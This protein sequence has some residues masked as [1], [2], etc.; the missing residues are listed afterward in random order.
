MKIST[1]AISLLVL[2]NLSGCAKD[3]TAIIEKLIVGTWDSH[4]ID[5]GKELYTGRLKFNKDGTGEIANEIN[6]F[7][8]GKKLTIKT[9]Y[10]ISIFDIKEY[11]AKRFV[12]SPAPESPDNNFDTSTLFYLKRVED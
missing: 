5:D 10:W 6:W 1:F 9:N 7:I 12:I 3:E 8:K 11:S 4:I 2:I